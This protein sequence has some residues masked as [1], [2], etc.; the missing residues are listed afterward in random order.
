MAYTMASSSLSWRCFPFLEKPSTTSC[1]MAVASCTGSDGSGGWCCWLGCGVDAR[2]TCCSSASRGRGNFFLVA[3]R[4]APR[5]KA[6]RTTWNHFAVV[7]SRK[8]ACNGR[9]RPVAHD[10]PSWQ[11]R[12][13][14]IAGRSSSHPGTWARFARPS[15][16]SAGTELARRISPRY[17]ART[18]QT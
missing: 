4:A 2:S 11:E 1:V 13:D 6:V 9:K 5:R 14:S 7:R 3:S 18:C 17:A 15:R 8:A 16:P 12:A 10:T